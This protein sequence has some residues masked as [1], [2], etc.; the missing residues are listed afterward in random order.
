MSGFEVLQSGPFVSV[1]DCGRPGMMRFGV[2]ASGPMDRTAF[3]IL[4]AALGGDATFSAIE[5]SLGGL[6]VRATGN[7]TVGFAGGEFSLS[8]NQT[9]LSPWSVFSMQSGDVLSIRAGTQGSWGYLGVCGQIVSPAWLGSTAAHLTTGLGGQAVRPGDGIEIQSPTQRTDLHASLPIAE[10]SVF[11]STVRAIPGPQ[12]QHFSRQ[13]LDDLA[14]KAFV[15]SKD[16]DRMGMRLSGPS[17]RPEAALSIPSEALVRGSV[18]V[19]GHGDPIIL[20]AEHQTTGGYPKIATIISADQD[21]LTQARSGQSLR[22]ELVDTL[23]AVNAAR[24]HQ[25]RVSA[26]IDSLPQW[27]GTLADR[28][29][30]LNLISGVTSGDAD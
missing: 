2:T 28:L 11:D 24:L 23:T 7:M 3:H 6:T 8:L 17:L 4:R 18:Q 20:L 29:G 26:Y 12:D 13:S 22:F 9:P 21:R 5:V 10:F 15:I 27:R 19:P 1:Q 16:Y 30:R 14:T 25:A